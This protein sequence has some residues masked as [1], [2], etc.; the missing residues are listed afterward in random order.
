[1][2]VSTVPFKNTD[3]QLQSIADKVYAGERITKEEGLLLF[4]KGDLA[5]VGSLANH[6]REKLHGDKVFFNR[7][8]HIEPT[9]VCV[10]SCNFCSYSRLY[11]HRE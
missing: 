3:P 6:V 8:F 2:L 1:M 4:E 5:F 11:S 9:N 7:N 10:F